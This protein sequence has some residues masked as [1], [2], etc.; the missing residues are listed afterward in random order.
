MQPGKT[1]NKAYCIVGSPILLEC[2]NGKIADEEESCN[3]FWV[4]RAPLII[5]LDSKVLL[6][7]RD[8]CVNLVLNS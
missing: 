5:F 6:T 3:A 2:T 1:C 4:E 8:T 7:N